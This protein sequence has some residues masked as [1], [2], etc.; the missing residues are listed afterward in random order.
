MASYL[1]RFEATPEAQRWPLVR[2]W[3]L[4]EPLPFY[5]ELRRDRPILAMPDVTLV[6]VPDVAGDSA[7]HFEIVALYVR[8]WFAVGPAAATDVPWILATVTAPTF[9]TLAS[10][11]MVCGAQVLVV[12]LKSNACAS[13]GPTAETN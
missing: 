7:C 4:G 6:T 13:V 8:T 9:D 5:A 2:G 1:Q 12:L 3:M 10:P 11:L